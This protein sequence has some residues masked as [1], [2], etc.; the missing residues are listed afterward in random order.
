MGQNTEVG[1]VIFSPVQVP[2]TTW[3]NSV[4][5]NQYAG[6]AV[7]TNGTLWAWGQNNYG[8]L[9]QNNLTEYSS[10]VQIPGTTWT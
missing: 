6:F 9:G 7:K 2:G 1:N 8:T 10:P 4:A 3:G 5:L